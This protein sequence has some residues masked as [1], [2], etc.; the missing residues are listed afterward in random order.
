MRLILTKSCK[1]FCWRALRGC[2]GVLSFSATVENA[3]SLYPNFSFTIVIVFT[4]VIENIVIV[5]FA[6]KIAHINKI[7]NVIM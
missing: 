6:F 1:C 7:S 2:M 4:I 5:Q 3:Q